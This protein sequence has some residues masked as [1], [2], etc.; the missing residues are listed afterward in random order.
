VVMPKVPFVRNRSV[1]FLISQILF[2]SI[3]YIFYDV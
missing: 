1:A 2:I 3:I